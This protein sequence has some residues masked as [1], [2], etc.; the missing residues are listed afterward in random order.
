MKTPG[1]HARE[2][3]DVLD[4]EARPAREQ[5]LRPARAS[6]SSD[7]DRQQ[8]VGDDAARAGHVPGDGLEVRCTRPRRRE[9]P[10]AAVR[11]LTP[12]GAT[13]RPGRP[14]SSSQ[15]GPVVAEQERCL[16]RDV[17]GEAARRRAR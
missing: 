11:E 16:R 15:S 17:G 3:V 7:D 2:A 14:R 10:P 12:S 1:E 13:K 6:P 5:R 8:D 4:G 9:A